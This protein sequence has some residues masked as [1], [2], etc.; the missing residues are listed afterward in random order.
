MHSPQAKG[1]GLSQRIDFPKYLATSKVVRHYG[2][3]LN[4]RDSDD[5]VL[6]ELTKV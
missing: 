1:L 6:R 4:R 5:L 3:Q 2:R